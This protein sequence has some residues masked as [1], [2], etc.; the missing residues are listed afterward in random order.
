MTAIAERVGGE[1]KGT[2]VPHFVFG[3]R[4]GELVVAEGFQVDSLVFGRQTIRHHR[5]GS[6]SIRTYPV[7]L[8]RAD[9]LDWKDYKTFLL[10]SQRF[11]WYTVSFRSGGSMMSTE[12]DQVISH[13]ATI[14]K[15]PK[16][17][18]Y[19]NLEHVQL[20]KIAELTYSQSD[21]WRATAGTDYIA[22]SPRDTRTEGQDEFFD[23]I[24]TAIA[25][26]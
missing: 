22:S 18:K 1:H 10:R 9:K 17:L 24:L 23:K 2:S 4:L 16:G 20:Y 19:S 13:S 8:E 3:K 26:A 15:V 7:A 6:N 5:D 25:Q 12:G 14:T 21:E 11:G